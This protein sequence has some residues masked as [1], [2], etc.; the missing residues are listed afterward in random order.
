[1]TGR[2]ARL[3]AVALLLAGCSRSAPPPFG[4]TRTSA[5]AQ[6]AVERALIG[7]VDPSR[8]RELHRELTRLPH[9]AGSPR[10]RELATWV[11]EH[12]REAGLEDVRLTTH[13]VLLP[14]PLEIAVEMSRPRAWS[15]DLRDGAATTPDTGLP[16]HAFSASGDVSAPLVFAGGG[17]AADYDW[18]S[19]KGID[20]RGRIVL[21]CSS[22]AAYRYKGLAAF[23]AQQRGAAAILMYS[24]TGIRGRGGPGDTVP[25]AE[26]RIERGS[27]LYDFIAPGDPSTP[28]LPSL[29]GTKRVATKGSSSLPRI[30]STPISARDARTLLQTLTGPAAPGWWSTSVLEGA[31]VGPGPGEVRVKVR[32]DDSMRPVWTVTGMLRGSDE[33]DQVVIVGNHRDAWVYGGVDPATG[34]A[35]TLELARALGSLA[36][37]GRR[38]KRSLLFASWDAEEFGLTSSVEWGEEHEEWL[39]SRAVAYLNVDSAGGGNRFVAGAA[40]SL[41]QLVEGA[42]EAVRDPVTG[43]PVASIER[44]RAANERGAAPDS[45][46][47]EDRL[48]GGSDYAVFLNHLGVPSADLAFDGPFRVYHSA[49][50]DH[51]FV[52]RQA[53]PGFRYTATL[54]Q[55]LGVSA[56]RLANAEVL[57]VDPVSTAA[58][59]AAYVGEFAQQLARARVTADTRELDASLA[60]LG[61]AAT[62]FAA[63]RD[64]ALSGE[65]PASLKSLN[66]RLLEFER[67]FVSPAGSRGRPWY[68]HVLHAPAPSYQP[69]VLPGLHEALNAGDQKQ[70][71]EE[72]A[73]LSSAF[74][75]ATALLRTD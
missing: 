55:V 21:V 31:R 18:L 34:T 17:T 65:A 53:D 47:V 26:T 11:S 67:A 1:M 74:R 9:P 37:E 45:G 28:G 2:S 41:T 49:D 75:R 59:A 64:R 7:R 25:D 71:V 52:D 15:A 72:L 39:R 56:L 20:V 19:S 30:V 5:P 60:E 73:R 16:Y 62:Q 44:S 66:R 58:R 36:R 51:A 32:M 29:P 22:T 50:D 13:D 54:A 10:D 61:R 46:I 8:I 70:L 35:A 3:A 63:E 33:P 27:I 38:P 43:V 48:G 4:F 24:D 12:Y 23:T 68:R 6:H 69:L 42:A 57:P 14:M 40:P